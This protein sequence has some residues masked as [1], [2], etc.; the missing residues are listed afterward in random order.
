M[1][2]LFQRRGTRVWYMTYWDPVAGKWVQKST[3]ERTEAAAKKVLKAMEDLQRRRAEAK[4]IDPGPLGE[5]VLRRGRRPKKLLVAEA[6][7][8]W[9][10]ERA[11]AGRSNFT[12][13]AG[14]V[15]NHLLPDLGD[16]PLDELRPRHIRAWIKSLESRPPLPGKGPTAGHEPQDERV[17]APRT[18]RRVYGTVHKMFEDFVADELIP[19]SPCRIKRE[20][21]PPDID[22]DQEWRDQAVFTVEEVEMLL[23]DD[24]IPEQRRVYY[25]LSFL[26]GLRHGEVAGLRM[27]HI[28]T[29]TQPLQKLLIAFSYG[30]RT[31]TKATRTVPVHP[32]LA[33]VLAEW[34]LSGFR[35]WTGRQWNAE[36]FVVPG[37]V[38]RSR[39]PERGDAAV[40]LTRHTAYKR[41]VNT[42]LP[43]LGLRHRRVGRSSPSRGPTGPEPRSSGTSPTRP[44][45][46]CSTCTPRSRGRRS[47]RRCSAS[48]SRGPSVARSRASPRCGG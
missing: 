48:R 45:A 37:P 17:L 31:K 33:A 47:A 32:V 30:G 12:T 16:H 6:A 4:G 41:F 26:A 35:R 7:K 38:A 46:P 9:L 15:E 11:N 28:D 27:R 5:P 2:S 25:A 21:L 18:V 34:K 8:R 22:R 1:A 19:R 36:D 3:G 44:P 13:E 39:A 42:D 23:S 43:T 20:D 10:E 24:R 29:T 14:H 40:M